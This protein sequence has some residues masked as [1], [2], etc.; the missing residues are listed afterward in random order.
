MI[1][2]WFKIFLRN[3]KKRPLYP[4]VNLLGLTAGITCFLLA[5]L[6]VGSEFSYEKWNPNVDQIYKNIIELPDGQVHVGSPRPLAEVN[7]AA[8]EEFTDYTQYKDEGEQLIS[9][10]TKDIFSQS[11]RVSKNFFEFFPFPFKY[12]DPKTAL[13]HPSNLIITA[14]LAQSIFGDINPVGKEVKINNEKPYTI[15]G[16]YELKGNNTQLDYFSAVILLTDKYDENDEWGNFNIHTYY[17]I[18]NE[19][20]DAAMTKKLTS[21]YLENAAKEMNSPIED[22]KKYFTM[23][24]YLENIGE[25]HLFS[26]GLKGK[27]TNNIFILSLLSLLLLVVCAINFVNL[28]ISGATQR[29]K[30]V[31]IRKTLGGSKKGITVQFVLEVMFLCLVAFCLSLALVEISLPS[32]GNLLDVDLHILNVLEY[33]PLILSTILILIVCAGLFPALYLSNFNPVKVLKGNFSRSK[34]GTV[35]K[36]GLMAFQFAICAVFLIGAFVINAQLKYM[37]E[38]DLGFNKEQ[39]MMIEVSDR[40]AL[41]PKTDMYKRELNKMPGVQKVFMSDRPPGT[42]AR[43]GSVTRVKY[44]EDYVT[45]DIHFIDHEFFPGMEIEILEGRNFLPTELFDTVGVNKVVVN[46]KFIREFNIEKPIG[47]TID[48]WE[49]DCEIIGV[50]KDYISKGFG[51]D[52]QPA[53]FAAGYR[54]SVV[55][56]R[57]DTEDIS[58]T[59]AAVED[60]WTTKIEPDYPLQYEFLDKDFA[61]LFEQHQKLQ[62]LVSALSAIMVLIALFGLFAVATHSI[63]QRYKEVAIRKTIGASEAQILGNLIKDFAIICLGAILVALPIA[64]VLSSRWLEDFT[65]RIDMPAI[66]YFVAPLLIFGLTIFIIWMQARKALSV[67][68]VKHL[69]FE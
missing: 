6:Y 36:K 60:F 53:L 2:N 14:E 35:L 18:P 62:T 57:L 4:M 45:T 33:L 47:K 10:G 31:A 56:L 7:V 67:D 65:Y 51:T 5:M 28:S 66:P 11:S 25:M 37:N 17:K 16:V 58:Q 52:I 68:L 22:V 38:K 50:V 61:A 49:Q 64:Y 43:Y 12:G 63:Q 3:I 44:I 26:R 59:I 42:M 23:D 54:T 48:L 55:M 39:V 34:S 32:F 20:D 24:F 15:A 69:K 9:Y 30:E 13:E 27:G 21:F 46:E 29:A 1:N 19:F 8:F 41:E 40:D